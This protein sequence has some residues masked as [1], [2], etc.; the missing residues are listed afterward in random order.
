MDMTQS[1]ATIA[2][3]IGFLICI[4]AALVLAFWPKSETPEA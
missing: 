2:I 3:I 4:A 1:I